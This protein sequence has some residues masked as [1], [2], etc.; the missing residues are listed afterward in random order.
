MI[1]VEARLFF[2]LGRNSCGPL[3]GMGFA[4]SN[5]MLALHF[6]LSSDLDENSL[7]Q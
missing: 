6:W 7:W 2:Y 3:M 1:G 5:S 4:G